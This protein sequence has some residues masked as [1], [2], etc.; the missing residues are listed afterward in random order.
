MQSINTQ[1]LEQAEK[2][3]KLKFG[4]ILENG[5]TVILSEITNDE[6]QLQLILARK[7]NGEWVTWIHHPESKCF[8]GH[9]FA[10]ERFK[11]A[12]LDFYDRLKF[13]KSH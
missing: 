12:V 3:S 9:Y 5:A 13:E 8:L 6:S 1:L 10:P 7:E 2:P 4:D 11:S